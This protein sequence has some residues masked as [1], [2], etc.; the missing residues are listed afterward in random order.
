[1]KK[2]LCFIAFLYV[3][4]PLSAQTF[5]YTKVF[6]TPG[7]R[8]NNLYYIFNQYT[9]I[10]TA[11]IATDEQ[12]NFYAVNTLID[13]N[14]TIDGIAFPNYNTAIVMV[15]SFRCDGSLRW[16]KPIYNI[17]QVST[18]GLRYN[19]GNIYVAGRF[20]DTAAIT[21]RH[22]GN[23]AITGHDFQHYFMASFDTLGTLNW[24]QFVGANDA[25]STIGGTGYGE[26][27]GIDDHYGY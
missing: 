26:T 17:G 3:C 12:K 25:S 16:A 6:T 21:N 8:G 24:I 4:L 2:V 27:F 22:I 13:S 1:M 11:F 5:N 10:K 20:L 14:L 23:T 7:A 15:T 18:H 19:N 9:T